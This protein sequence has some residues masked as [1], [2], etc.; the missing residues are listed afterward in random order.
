MGANKKRIKTWQQEGTSRNSF[1]ISLKFFNI[2]KN[3]QLPK[4]KNLR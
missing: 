2:K 3:Q 4:N 1:K